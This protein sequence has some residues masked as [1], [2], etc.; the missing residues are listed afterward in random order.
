MRCLA[1]FLSRLINKII[2]EYACIF[3][4]YGR[5]SS[6]NDRL[7]AEHELASTTTEQSSGKMIRYERIRSDMNESDQI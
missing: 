2:S 4:I 1:K 7:A 6:N 5:S 3:G